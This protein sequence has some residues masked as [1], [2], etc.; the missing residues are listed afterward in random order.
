VAEHFGGI[1]HHDHL[2]EKTR[3]IEC[4][5]FERLLIAPNYIHVH[6]GHHLYPSVPFYNLRKLQ[7]LLMQNPDYARRAHVTNGYIAFL[8]ELLGSTSK[9]L[10]HA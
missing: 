2:L 8:R 4:N 9:E 5:L 6:I 7:E 3:H 10:K 1:E